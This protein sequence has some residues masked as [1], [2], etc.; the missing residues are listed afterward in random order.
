MR[1]QGKLPW[2]EHCSS[3][4]NTAS[5]GAPWTEGLS[6]VDLFHRSDRNDAFQLGT[7][8]Y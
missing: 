6:Y 8:M 1:R 5:G 3:H 7:K 2:I 4:F